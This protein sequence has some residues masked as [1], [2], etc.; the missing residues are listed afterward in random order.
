MRLQDGSHGLAPSAAARRTPPGRGRRCAA[1][2]RRTGRY[3]VPVIRLSPHVHEALDQGRPVVALES[4][5]L[6]HG[7]PRPRNLAFGRHL[8][9]VVREEGAV[10]A[11]VGLVHGQL[12]VGLDDEQMVLLASHD[13]A[14]ASAWNL[15]GLMADGRSAGTTVAT[16][17]LAAAAAGIETFATGGIGGVHFDDFDESADLPALARYPLVTVCAGPKSVLNVPATLERLETMGVPVLGWREERLAGFHLPTTELRLPL[18]VDTPAQVADVFRTH[19]ALG[20]PGGVLLSQPVEQG[21]DKAALAGWMT[22]A[23][24][25]LAASGARGKDVTP[26]MLAALAEASGGATVEVNLRLLEGN[27]RLAAQVAAALLRSEVGGP[28]QGLQAVEVSR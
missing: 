4:T 11:T 24:A 12:V 26:A 5:V 17:L 7:L 10:P 21:L 15:A 25:S 3:A 13:V 23:K 27:A 8:E 22:Q 1:T 20:L 14:K 2:G 18:R 6:S 16:T 19:R 9:Q 28:G